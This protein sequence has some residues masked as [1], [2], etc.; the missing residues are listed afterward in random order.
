M[1]KYENQEAEQ[2][3]L[4]TVIM[5]NSL[6]LNLV[7][8]LESKHFFYIEH[9]EIWKEFIRIAK[10]GEVADFVTLKNFLQNNKIFDEVA[11]SK[12]L[13][14]LTQLASGIIDLRSYAKILIELWQKRELENLI[15]DCKKNLQHKNFNFISSQF[16]ND[17]LK[18][19]VNNSVSKIQHISEMIDDI[20]NEESQLINDEFVKSGFNKLDNIL[21]GG[22]HKK[23]LVVV[24]AR[25]SVGKTSIAQ[26]FILEAGKQKK[27]ALFLSLEVDKKN[28]FLKF[29]SNLVSI[30]GWKLQTKK[31][32][33]SEFEAIKTAKEDL[34][35]MKI[36]VN[37]SSSLN[38]LQIENIIKKQL[39]IENIDIVF[40]DYIQIIRYQQQNNF[41]EAFA[42]KENTSRLKEIAKK[43]NISVVALAQINRKGVENNQEPKITD[44]KGSGGI[45]EDA[46]V[47]ILLHRE[48]N[49]DKQ[50]GYF[51]NNG[52]MIIAKNRH[53]ATG[54]V[55][56][57]FDGKFSRFTEIFNN[58]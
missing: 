12:Y 1:T 3:I 58:F 24:G 18:L 31:L 38:I 32:N 42:I 11:N 49:E 52:K 20:E 25:P 53:G 13:I 41:N 57:D 43:Y 46:D 30:E 21:N 35:N 6:L 40:I 56:F 8:I 22:F 47:A 39:E 7:D 44:L 33:Q 51:S 9:Q 55:N 36:F 54:V 29:V 45:E 37:D 14:T 19:E 5:N 15:E 26:Q 23:Q 34:R 28:V 50:S 10:N 27:K 16:Q 17:I 4:G 48:K 2:V